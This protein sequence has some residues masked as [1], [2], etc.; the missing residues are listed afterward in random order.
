MD[1]QQYAAANPEKF[2]KPSNEGTNSVDSQLKFDE[3]VR[4]TKKKAIRVCVTLGV[5]SAVLMAILY[6]IC[7]PSIKIR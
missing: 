2:R 3:H 5:I 7:L 1:A 4:D 6:G